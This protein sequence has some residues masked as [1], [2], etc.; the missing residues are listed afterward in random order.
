MY[1]CV[2]ARVCVCDPN[3]AIVELLLLLYLLLLLGT[4]MKFVP[5]VFVVVS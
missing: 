3:N 1:V 4:R 2:C 5:Y